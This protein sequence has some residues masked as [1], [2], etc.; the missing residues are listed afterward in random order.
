MIKRSHFDFRKIGPLQQGSFTF[1]LIT[2]ISLICFAFRLRTMQAW[3]M[4]LSPVF[5]YICYNSILGAF[6]QKWF[7]Y[8]GQ[9]IVIFILL[10]LYIYIAGNFVSDFSYR[11]TDELQRITVLVILFYFLLNLLCLVFRSLLNLLEQIDE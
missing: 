10:C 4:I 8:I 3:N 2:I 9:S 7:Q 5:L 1:L 11:E 6:R